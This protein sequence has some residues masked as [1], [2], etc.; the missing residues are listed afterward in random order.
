[1]SPGVLNFA[2]PCNFETYCYI[3]SGLTLMLCGPTYRVSHELPPESQDYILSRGSGIIGVNEDT[4]IECKTREKSAM[5]YICC[6]D[7]SDT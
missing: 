3:L 1:M 6:Y 4:K 5:I 2:I 7:K